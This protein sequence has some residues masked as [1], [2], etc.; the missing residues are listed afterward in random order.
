M[1]QSCCSN[2]DSIVSLLTNS[3]QPRFVVWLLCRQRFFAYWSINPSNNTRL[4]SANQ[5][6]RSG[7]ISTEVPPVR[8]CTSYVGNQL[9]QVDG[10][11]LAH[12]SKAHLQDA[13][14]SAGIAQMHWDRLHRRLD[15]L[16]LNSNEENK[17][18]GAMVSQCERVVLHS[19]GPKCMFK[20]D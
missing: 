2:G 4:S 12:T 1:S 10:E 17:L 3:L 16:R 6:F 13:F 7:N 14:A 11:A 8:E 15:P 5:N 19:L 20:Y 9:Q 18:E